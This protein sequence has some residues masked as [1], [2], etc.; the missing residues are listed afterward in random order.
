MV[1]EIVEQSC[2]EHA[3]AGHRSPGRHRKPT[4]GVMGETG[5]GRREAVP[6]LSAIAALLR[7]FP[8]SQ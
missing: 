8:V 7:F 3:V 2:R 1:K 6:T 4:P 5:T